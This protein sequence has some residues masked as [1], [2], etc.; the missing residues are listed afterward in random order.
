[1]K[2][3]KAF[4][5]EKCKKTIKIYSLYKLYLLYKKLIGL[6]PLLLAEM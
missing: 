4:V 6:S 1:M 2:S 5:I 3:D